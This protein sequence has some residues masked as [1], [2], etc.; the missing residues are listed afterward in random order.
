MKEKIIAAFAP[1][2]DLARV[3]PGF[4]PRPAQTKM[5]QF[6]TDVLSRGLMGIVEAGTGTGKSLAY[7]APVLAMLPPEERLIISTHN[8]HLQQQIMSKDLPLAQKILPEPPAVTLLFGRGNYLCRRKVMG[9]KENVTTLSEEERRFLLQIEEAMD[10]E[11]GHR[12]E[13]PFAV[14]H[15]LWNLLSSD[16]KTCLKSH[17]PWSN[18]C[19]WQSARKAANNARVIV[20]NHHLLMADLAIRL[21]AGWET[22]R[23]ILPSYQWVVADEAHHLEDVAVDYLGFHFHEDELRFRLE[24]LLRRD[25]HKKRGWLPGLRE[26]ILE[27]AKDLAELQSLL[28][29]LEKQLIPA[30]T[31]LESKGELFF[32]TLKKVTEQKG[33]GGELSRVWRFKEDLTAIEGMETA[34]DDFFLQLERTVDLVSGFVDCLEDDQAGSEEAVFLAETGRDLSELRRGLPVALNGESRET[35]HWL[36]NKASNSGSLHQAPLELGPLLH[37]AFLSHLHGAIFTSATLTVG[38]RTDYFRDGLGLD[39]IH[40]SLRREIILPPA[41]DYNSQ[42]LVL[43]PK[44]IS[45]PDRPE[46]TADIIALLPKILGESQGRA[47]VLFTSRQQMMEVYDK[48]KPELVKMGMTIMVQGQ[49]SRHR[50]LHRFRHSKSPVLFGMDSFW[51]GVDIPGDQLSCVVMTRLPFRV[52]S[53]PIQEARIEALQRTGADSFHRLSLPQAVI[54]FK[55]GFGRLIRS[56]DDRGVVV[57]LDARLAKK[58]YG[59]KFI[60]SLP[61]GEVRFVVKGQLARE[62]RDWM[63]GQT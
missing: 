14:D 33:R 57:V 7:L 36:E 38:G 30:F 45:E 61:G 10:K 23:A 27:R 21:Q 8:I 34:I 62:L 43:C 54:K 50:L 58:S 12:H 15:L 24:R 3:M 17:C 55:Q 22:E 18:A 31:E 52:P 19:F 9:W 4:H 60:D 41:F 5:V 42:A 16:S 35:V 56:Q 26:K 49:T 59:K 37:K 47:F 6:V 2:G 44:D 51:E 32:Q 25:G 13:M 63:D 20:V 53:E 46:Y 1:Q 29:M 48:V 11:F 39:H 28:S 40:S